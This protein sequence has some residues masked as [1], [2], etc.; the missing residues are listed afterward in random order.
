MQEVEKFQLLASTS[1]ASKV[2]DF[3]Y[4]TRPSSDATSQEVIFLASREARVN[5]I[6]WNVKVCGAIGGR[7]ES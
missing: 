2:A 5:R 6:F 4:F 7:K 3:L 1:L